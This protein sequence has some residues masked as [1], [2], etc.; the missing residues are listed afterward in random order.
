MLSRPRIV[1]LLLMLL[2][3]LLL[4][5]LVVKEVISKLFELLEKRHLD[6]QNNPLSEPAGFF[7]CCW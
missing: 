3:L 7:F 2:R 6:G 1:L 4:I 5:I